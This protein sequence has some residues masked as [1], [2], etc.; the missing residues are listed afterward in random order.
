MEKADLDLCPDDSLDTLGVATALGLVAKMPSD[1]GHDQV[2]RFASVQQ[3]SKVLWQAVKLVAS[4]IERDDGVLVSDNTIQENA[5][6]DESR[7]VCCHLDHC[8]AA[9]VTG[10]KP[11]TSR[12]DGLSSANRSHK[13]MPDLPVHRPVAGQ[14]ASAKWAASVGSPLC[15]KSDAPLVNAL[16]CP[17]GNSIDL[18]FGLAKLP[19]QSRDLVTKALSQQSDQTKSAV[20]PEMTEA[21]VRDTSKFRFV[22]QHS[23]L[24]SKERF[25]F[26]AAKGGD[27]P[28]WPSPLREH[29]AFNANKLSWPLMPRSGSNTCAARTS[30]IRLRFVTSHSSTP[31]APPARSFICFGRLRNIR[32]FV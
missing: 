25:S 15:H 30:S 1:A 6:T 32:D 31:L 3:V 7:L 19:I 17:N 8:S 18:A 11:G 13:G 4:S 24:S 22:L 16:Q 2:T 20:M 14:K 9:A 5:W 10:A 21:C 23:W 27:V 26:I 28:V 29:C 12:T